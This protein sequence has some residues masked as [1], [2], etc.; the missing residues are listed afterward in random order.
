VTTFA[1]IPL[2]EFGNLLASFSFTRQIDAIHLHHTWR[3]NHRQY[4]GHDTILS[5]WRYHTEE[6]GWSDIAQHLTI[7]PDGTLW[8]GRNWNQPPASASGHNGNTVSGPFMIEVIGDFD[9][10]QDRFEGKQRE[11]TLQVIHALQTTRDL[12]VESLRFHNQ[13][14]QKTCPGS[15]LNRQAVLKELRRLLTEPAAR[16]GT[17]RKARTDGE[18][19]FG[20]ETLAVHG[21]LEALRSS[22]REKVDPLDAELVEGQDEAI[23]N[24]MPVGTRSLRARGGRVSEDITA[25]M[26]HDLRP[27]V[28]NL[29]QGR[30]SKEGKFQ[31]TEGDVDAIFEQ[32]LPKWIKDLTSQS[33][34][35]K[36]LFYAH[37]GLTSESAGL[38][39]AHQQTAWW[40]ANGIYPIY[41]VWETGFLET[42]KQLLSRSRELQRALPRDFDPAFLSD[43]AIEGICRTFGGDTIW[44]GMKRSAEQASADQGGATY[45]AK[46]LKAFLEKQGGRV[47][48][49]AVGHSAGSIFHAHF[50]PMALNHKVRP[51]ESM[52]FLAPAIRLD[53]FL[54]QFK[55]HLGSGVKHLTLFTMNKDLENDDNC[56]H[57]YRKSLLYLIHH[58]LEAERATPILGLEV[59]LRSNTELK[60]IFGLDGTDS[61]IGEVI[62]SKTESPTGRSASLSTTH[63]GFDNDAATMNSV[64]R[65]ILGLKD[66]ETLSQTFPEEATRGLVES[67]SQQTEWPEELEFLARPMALSSTPASET[68]SPSVAFT[69]AGPSN[70]VGADGAGQKRALCVGIDQ[71]RTAPLAGCV[72]DARAWAQ[73]LRELGFEEQRL[74]LDQQANR[75]SILEALTTLVTNSAPG[76]IIVFQYAGHGTTLPDADG[77]EAGGDTPA[78]DEALCPIDFAEGKFVIDDDVAE[79]FQRLPNGV[80]LSCFIDCCHSGTISRFAVGGPGEVTDASRRA[81]YLVA[82][83]EMKQAHRQFRLQAGRSR[84][85]DRRGPETMGEVVFSACLSSEVALESSGHGDFTTRALEVLRAGIDGLTNEQFQERVVRA[86]GAQPRQHP[87]LDCAPAARARGLFRPFVG[88][89]TVPSRSGDRSQPAGQSMP[90]PTYLSNG[91]VVID[92]AVLTQLLKAVTSCLEAK[93][94]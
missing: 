2:S 94:K 93:V 85:T 82:T 10:G 91:N 58:G 12:P 27:H 15:S 44:S 39:I 19:P 51:F 65:R 43:R 53:T 11:A 26:L 29:N 78:N 38:W 60:E 70:Q 55:P 80:N 46:K 72:A 63:G 49:H 92:S 20:A 68:F 17:P 21:F 24:A 8:L 76:D 1:Q 88:T 83:P 79:I 23:Y 89:A 14:S 81:R 37:G 71:Y 73:A 50:L 33:Q 47:E 40:K 54:Q 34:K 3:P 62:W 57:I 9:T 35:V 75:S 13:M 67:W 16:K 48:L 5:M 86:F 45:A 77:D 36:L 84:A 66:S 64:A 56:F 87:M 74:L 69:T 52:H 61:K 31:T 28:I 32:H 25:D 4:K 59:S 7:A 30:F 18:R 90:S 42:L 41:F 22:P 6:K